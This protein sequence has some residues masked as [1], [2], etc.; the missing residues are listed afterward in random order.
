M[1]EANVK[2]E[3]HPNINSLR[4]EV[5]CAVAHGL[6]NAR[7]L[8]DSVKQGKADYHFIEIMACPGGCLGGGGQPFPQPPKSDKRGLRPSTK[9]ICQ[10]RCVNR[11][12]ILKSLGFTKSF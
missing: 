12:K 5:K 9:R 7:T 6:A 8:M 1:K 11:T 3:K 10:C 2:I 4:V